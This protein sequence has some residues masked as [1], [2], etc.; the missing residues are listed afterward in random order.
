[1]LRLKPEDLL[2]LTR[3]QLRHM[4]YLIRNEAGRSVDQAGLSGHPVAQLADAMFSS[5]ERLATAVLPGLESG[6][7]VQIVPVMSF[8]VRAGDE[9]AARKRFCRLHYALAKGLLERFG[10]HNALI[11]ETSFDLAF[12]ELTERHADAVWSRYLPGTNESRDQALTVSAALAVRLAEARPIQRFDLEKRHQDTPTHLLL[13][14]N[15]FVALVA[16]LSTAILSARDDGETLDRDE[17]LASAIDVVDLRFARFADVFRSRDRVAAL[18]A[19][20]AAL[21]PH[22]P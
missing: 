15:R 19:E 22:L 16:G 11:S 5:A 14:A 7:S 18:K 3:D 9:S 4:R 20:F 10:A 17:V 12:D 8:F 6:G 1:M 13:D 21:V 2:S